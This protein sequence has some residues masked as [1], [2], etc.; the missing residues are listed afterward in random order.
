MHS[1]SCGWWLVLPVSF[2][3]PFNFDFSSVL[4]HWA[5]KV[6]ERHQSKNIIVN[7]LVKKVLLVSGRLAPILVAGERDP[8]PNMNGDVSFRM[9]V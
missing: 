7:L 3:R 8:F 5:R 6:M 2:S 9:V 1:T 4:W